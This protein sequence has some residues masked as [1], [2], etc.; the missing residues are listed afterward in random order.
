MQFSYRVNLHRRRLTAVQA[1][2]PEREEGAEPD[3]RDN[4]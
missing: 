4:W 2:S 3:Y 1:S